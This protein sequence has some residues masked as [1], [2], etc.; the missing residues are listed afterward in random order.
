M[1]ANQKTAILVAALVA[2]TPAAAFADG[3]GKS[4][5]RGEGKGKS[6]APGQVCKSHKVKGKKTAEQ[7][8][9]FK[10][11]IK[12]AAEAKRRQKRERDAAES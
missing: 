2:A 8:A 12:E 7:R 5:A 10:N 1:R 6:T 11:C 3:P 9:A 4:G